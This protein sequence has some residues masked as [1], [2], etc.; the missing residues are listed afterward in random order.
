M[1]LVQADPEEACT[2]LINDVKGKAVLVKRGSCE[3][4]KKAEVVRDAGGTAIIVGST[5]PYIVRMVRVIIYFK[6]CNSSAEF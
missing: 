4:L 5:Y 6:L 3:F 2:S 1:P